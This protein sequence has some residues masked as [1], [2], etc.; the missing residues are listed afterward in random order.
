[1]FQSCS[2]PIKAGRGASVADSLQASSAD[3]EKKGLLGTTEGKDKI[4][5]DVY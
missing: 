1:M 5:V 2:A 4:A 3:Q